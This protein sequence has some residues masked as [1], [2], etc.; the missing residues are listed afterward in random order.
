M[1]SSRWRQIL[2]SIFVTPSHLGNEEVM[3]IP[4][5]YFANTSRKAPTY[6]ALA[7][8]N[9]APSLA[10]LTRDLE[11]PC[12]TKRLL[13]SSTHVLQRPVETAPQLRHSTGVQRMSGT[14]ETHHSQP[15]LRFSSR[16]RRLN[17][18]QE[19]LNKIRRR[20]VPSPMYVPAAVRKCSIACLLEVADMYPAFGSACVACRGPVGS[21]HAPLSH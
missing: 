4:I 2:T 6:R 14:A 10:S 11:R 21:T 8:R 3:K 17:T 19:T 13:R 9:S 16:E 18:R 12:N 1:Q 20:S 15:K 7:K 5:D